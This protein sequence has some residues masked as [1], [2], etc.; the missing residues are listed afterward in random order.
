M[1]GV[2]QKI[3]RE[4]LRLS[5]VAMMAGAELL[6]VW[7]LIRNILLLLLR[8]P[9]AAIGGVSFF[10]GTLLVLFLFCIG[11]GSFFEFFTGMIFFIL[12]AVLLYRIAGWVYSLVEMALGIALSAVGC[13]RILTSLVIKAERT[14]ERYLNAFPQDAPERAG[15]WIFGV[16]YVIHWGNRLAGKICDVVQFLIYPLTI[17]AGLYGFWWVCD[18]ERGFSSFKAVDH[19]L[20]A[21]TVALVVGIA[22]RVGHEL[23]RAITEARGSLRIL[24]EFFAIYGSY[25]KRNRTSADDGRR[26]EQGQYKHTY[27][28]AGEKAGTEP[29]P[30][31]DNPYIQI[32]EKAAT[33]EELQKLYRSNMKKLHPD[34]CKDYSQEESNRRAAQLNAAYESCKG[35]FGKF[36]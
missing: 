1:M 24:G 23:V 4:C 20:F 7:Q 9:Y 28:D 35:R 2:F 27:E 19:L 22:V 26:Q 15:F 16:P 21:A 10:I 36:A 14:M 18:F 3:K 8:V 17:G 30:R 25:F 29:K 11:F 33:A 13:E 32:L 34:V 12:L 5:A 31:S 6:G